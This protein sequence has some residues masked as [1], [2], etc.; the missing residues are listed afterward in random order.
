MTLTREQILASAARRDTRVVEVK[1]WGG[2]VYV[3]MLNGVEQLEF[4]DAVQGKPRA[5]Q[6]ATY[7]VY[8]VCDQ[9]GEPLFKPGDEAEIGKLQWNVLKRVFTEASKFNALTD[10][11]IEDLRK[12]SE[13]GRSDGSP[14]V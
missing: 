5:R 14:S 9:H 10:D 7:L 1:A 8:T 12:N 13:P 2:T 3:R 6:M 11:D 4:E